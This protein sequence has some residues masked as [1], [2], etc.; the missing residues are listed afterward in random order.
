MIGNSGSEFGVRGYV[1]AFDAQSGKEA[2]RF[3]VTGDP[4]K[5]FE[6]KAMEAAAKT[7]SGNWWKTGGGGSPWNCLSYD[8]ET[9]LVIFGTG[10]GSP[11]NDK[12]RWT[13]KATIS[14]CH[15]L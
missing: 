10:N 2:W 7:W 3:Y 12:A 4:R 6:N 15:R 9:N 11:W 5:P 14:T 1:A 13:A 8:P